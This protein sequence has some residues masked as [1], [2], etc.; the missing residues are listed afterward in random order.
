MANQSEKKRLEKEEARDTNQRG[1]K[2]ENAKLHQSRPREDL[3]PTTT[4]DRSSAFSI[5]N[6]D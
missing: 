6:G 2:P 3:T 4:K 5:I 1:H